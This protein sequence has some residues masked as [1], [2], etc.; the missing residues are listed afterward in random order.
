MPTVL[1]TGT[2][3]G[4]GQLTTEL[5]AARGWRVFATMR[6]L[7]KKDSLERALKQAGLSDRVTLKQLDVD[8]G[9]GQIAQTGNTLDA[10]VHNAGAAIVG[11]LED[12]PESEIRRVMETNFFGV[13]ELTR[14]LFAHV[15]RA[16]VRPHRSGLEPGGAGRPAGKLN[17]LHFEMGSRRMG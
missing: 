6:D 17:L 4:F 15:S 1:I 16:K 7:T 11:A 13:I 12:M 2:S 10:V 8:R 3:T 9:S 5:L 14:A